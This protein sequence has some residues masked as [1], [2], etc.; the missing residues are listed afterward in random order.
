[1]KKAKAPIGNAKRPHKADGL[2]VSR[3]SPRAAILTT[4]QGVRTP[5]TLP[6]QLRP[7]AVDAYEFDQSRQPVLATGEQSDSC[8]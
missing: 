8:P 1:M 4:D 2:E 6:S 7:G 3:E 5:Q